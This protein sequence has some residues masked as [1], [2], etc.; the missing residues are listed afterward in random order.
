[1]E[2]IQF[3]KF[4]GAGNDFILIDKKLSSG[5]IPDKNLIQQMCKRGSGIGADGFLI[6]SDIENYDFNMQYFNSDGTEGF[7]CAN[8]ARCSVRY[9][10]LSSRINDKAD[11]TCCGKKYSAFL[12]NDNSVT[13]NLNDPTDL[14]R[15]ITVEFENQSVNAAF[16]DTGARHVVINAEDITNIKSGEKYSLETLPVYHLGKIIRNLPEFAP[17]GTN[18]NFIKIEK[19]KIFIR[20]FEKG[21]EDETLACGTGSV[22]AAVISF[23]NKKVSSPVTIIPKSLDLLIVNFDYINNS[24]KNISLTGPAKLIY[25]GEY[26][27]I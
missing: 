21:V 3:F 6:I 24:I 17:F 8:G 26:L 27:N 1:M 13:L 4:S 23:L 10:K 2:K 7:L 14:K 11:F 12:N 20:T 15:E 18:V 25:A 5:F 16:I 9:A 19:G 22:A